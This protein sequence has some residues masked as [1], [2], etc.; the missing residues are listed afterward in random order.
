MASMISIVSFLPLS[1]LALTHWKRNY[2]SQL[3]ITR[4]IPCRER[5]VL[6]VLLFD[7]RWLFLFLP[8]LTPVDDGMQVVSWTSIGPFEL[9][10]VE[11]F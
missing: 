9:Q 7:R 8:R 3:Q 11:D 2:S 4:Q 1:I 10:K 5:L 6:K